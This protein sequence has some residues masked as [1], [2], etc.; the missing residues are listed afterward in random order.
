MI[1]APKRTDGLKS[2]F[3][4][5]SALLL[6]ATLGFLSTILDVPALLIV[7]VLLVL[8][9][10]ILVLPSWRSERK[11]GLLFR[12]ANQLMENFIENTGDNKELQSANGAT[13]VCEFTECFNQLLAEA[14][15]CRIQFKELEERSIQTEGE[16]P[17]LVT[18]VSQHMQ[19]QLVYIEQIRERLDGVGH[20]IDEISKT[21]QQTN[22]S[23]ARSEA[24]GKSGKLVMTEAVGN[25]MML[26]NS[27]NN[28][29]EMITKLGEDSKTIG[30]ITEV[31]QGVAEQTNLLALNAAIEAARAGEQGRGF[32]VVADEVRSLASKTQDS[33][34]KINHIIQ[35]LLAHVK[36]AA[37]V[38]TTSQQTASQSEEQIEQVIVS[39]S[40][41]VGLMTGV[42]K[43]SDRLDLVVKEEED[44]RVI[45]DQA[46]TGLQHS[47]MAL[48]EQ[49]RMTSQA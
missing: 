27:V 18:M 34:Q 29:S 39:Y 11:L 41:L 32:A 17:S 49:T 7:L 14:R 37:N 45:L 5:M 43:L 24:E 8:S 15:A 31:I 16:V 13:I 2:L 23:S 3:L 46:L 20:L 36:E 10:A 47:C 35:Q 4:I 28:V 1:K 38:I 19:E 40:E 48:Q 9:Y 44:S 33:A 42:S 26:V 21:A 22:D 12:Q 25:I 6:I 30:G